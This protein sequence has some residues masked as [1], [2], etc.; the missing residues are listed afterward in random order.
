M[1]TCWLSGKSVRFRRYEKTYVCHCYF[2]YLNRCTVQCGSTLVRR[3]TE[4]REILYKARETRRT[5]SEKFS[6]LPYTVF[7]QYYTTRQLSLI[8][9]IF[10]TVIHRHSHYQYP[11]FTHS[12]I[13]TR[14]VDTVTM[15]TLSFTLILFRSDVHSRGLKFC[16][17]ICMK[18][19]LTVI[20]LVCWMKRDCFFLL[21]CKPWT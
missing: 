12:L 3:L 10:V 19:T 20:L 7:S 16:R 1:Y 11:H 9:S 17:L 8:A 4:T 14:D 6:V 21:D 18:G 15:C 5:I 13:N 2:Q